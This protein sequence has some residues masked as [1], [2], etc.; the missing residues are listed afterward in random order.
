MPS[1]GIASVKPTSTPK[2]VE[3]PATAGRISDPDASVP[4]A[5]LI[6]R[7]LPHREPAVSSRK[8]LPWI[9]LGL[10]GL[11]G[12]GL[13]TLSC[14]RRGQLPTVPEG[15]K[16]DPMRANGLVMKEPLSGQ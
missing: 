4:L 6:V 1:T 9:G 5:E 2:P 14:V 8:W 15:K 13:V 12:A 11:V 10:A 7:G 3:P 16:L